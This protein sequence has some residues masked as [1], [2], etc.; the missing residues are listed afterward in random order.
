MI[1]IIRIH[2]ILLLVQ[3]EHDPAYV[4]PIPGLNA[5]RINSNG[6]SAVDTPSSAGRL[7][8]VSVMFLIVAFAIYVKDCSF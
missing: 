4:Q 1:V 8:R 6:T 2:P 7:E 5:T 3:L